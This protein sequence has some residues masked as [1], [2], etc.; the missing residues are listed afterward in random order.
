MISYRKIEH[1]FFTFQNFRAC[2]A[3]FSIHMI[4]LRLR[5]YIYLNLCVNYASFKTFNT[6][7]EDMQ[8]K[9]PEYE[10][11]EDALVQLN[12]KLKAEAMF[13]MPK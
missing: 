12:A 8:N 4:M 1:T 7:L 6:I 13:S 9:I 10:K 3:E 2:G 5:C 11:A